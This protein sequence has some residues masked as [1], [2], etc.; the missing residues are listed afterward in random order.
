MDNSSNL[1]LTCLPR[2]QIEAALGAAIRFLGR[3]EDGLTASNREELGQDA[4]VMALLRWPT[5]RDKDCFHAFVRTIARRRRAVAL[6]TDTRMPTSSIDADWRL[7]EQVLAP[8]TTE[9]EFRIAGDWVSCDELVE[10]LPDALRRLT[11]LNATLLMS[12]YEGFSCTEL[13]VRHELPA[14]NVKVRIHRARRRV[15]ELLQ[16]HLRRQA[17]AREPG[18]PALR[19]ITREPSKTG[20]EAV[21]RPLQPK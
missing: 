5:L 20:D 15:R 18:L 17:A 19:Q 11:R 2:G 10:A 4:V 9:E 6:D 12:Y 21:S 1:Q 3:W 8:E 16:R 7:A 13:A 14:E